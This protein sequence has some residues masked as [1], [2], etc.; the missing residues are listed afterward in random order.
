MVM[1]EKE[2]KYSLFRFL[3]WPL[4]AFEES[5]E[6]RKKD[7]NIPA[8]AKSRKYPIRALRYWWLDCAIHEEL[9]RIEGSPT[10]ADVGC[11]TGI[12]KEFVSN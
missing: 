5:K 6:L 9:Q 1:V 2:K 8:E 7:F 12:L 4:T 3:K 11:E 10:I